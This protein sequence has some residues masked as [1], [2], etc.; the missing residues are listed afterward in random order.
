MLEKKSRS[1]RPESGAA[2]TRR[3]AHLP[4][5]RSAG[6][7]E[8][9]FAGAQPIH[10]TDGRRI[11]VVANG[12]P[13]WRGA[14]IAID[15]TLVSPVQRNG[16]PRARAHARPALALQQAKARMF[17]TYPELQPGGQARCCLVVFGLEVGGRFDRQAV[18]LLRQLARA[19]ARDRVSW[20]R[21][22]AIAALTRRWTALAA[23]AA[24]HA[25]AQSLLELPIRPMAQS[26]RWESSRR[27][28]RR[29]PVASS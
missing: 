11:E 19:R 7:H 8:R 24:L 13:L 21:A 27:S 15:T 22:A 3:R 14:Q 17:R 28:R 1:P 26:C 9:R 29:S 20:A 16:L 6:R 2:G 10:A 4:G 5:S 18:A 23:L 12:L 25:H